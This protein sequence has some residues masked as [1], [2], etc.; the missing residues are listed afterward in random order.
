MQT[1][2]DSVPQAR[3]SKWAVVS[4]LIFPVWFLL[5]CLLYFLLVRPYAV[6]ANHRSLECWPPCPGAA[7]YMFLFTLATV[8][9]GSI[10]IGCIAEWRI[11]QSGGLLRGK[12]LARSAYI[13]GYAILLI[14]TLCMVAL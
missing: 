4:A 5:L 6:L 11:Q 1:Q 7:I 3:F 8:V 2:A 9:L 13:L 14:I 10:V 12:W